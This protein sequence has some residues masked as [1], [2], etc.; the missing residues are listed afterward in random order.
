MKKTDSL[1]L[2]LIVYTFVQLPNFESQRKKE[3]NMQTWEI[4]RQA[5]AF[6][7]KNIFKDVFNKQVVV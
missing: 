7:K 2:A 4:C 5:Y 1:F 6:L 3:N